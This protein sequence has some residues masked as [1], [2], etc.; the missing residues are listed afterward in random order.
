MTTYPKNFCEMT[1]RQR[2][3][4]MQKNDWTYDRKSGFANASAEYERLSQE[5]GRLIQSSAH[6]LMRGGSYQVGGL[7]MAQLA[8]VHDLAPKK[9]RTS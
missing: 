8:H 7:I 9:W 1:T 4:W 2:R 3:A 5:V 6:L